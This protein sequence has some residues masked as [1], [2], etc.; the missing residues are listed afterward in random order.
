M[1]L[2][3]PRLPSERFVSAT[4][5]PMSTAVLSLRTVCGHS[6][7]QVQGQ[8]LSAERLQQLAQSAQQM[9]RAAPEA[10]KLLDSRQYAVACR[11]LFQHLHDPALPKLA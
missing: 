5:L 9:C 2:L 11:C 3:P 10:A 4:A 8:A 6:G 1:E 7:W